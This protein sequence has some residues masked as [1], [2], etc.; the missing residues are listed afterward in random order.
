MGSEKYCYRVYIEFCIMHKIRCYQPQ[1]RKYSEHLNGSF[2]QQALGMK[3]GALFGIL[4]CWFHIMF[5]I[6]SKKKATLTFC[7]QQRY[8]NTDSIHCLA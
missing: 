4:I 6:V 2:H 8:S 5:K 3:S 7:F 1:Y